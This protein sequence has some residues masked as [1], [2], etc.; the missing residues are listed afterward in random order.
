MADNQNASHWIHCPI[1][2]AKTRTKVYSDTVM[3]NFPLFCPKC[4]K[5][6]KINIFQ[7]KMAKSK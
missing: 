7:L 5:E 6:T 1:C 3:F 2:D 4:K